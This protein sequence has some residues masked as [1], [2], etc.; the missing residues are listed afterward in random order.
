MHYGSSND[1]NS[2]NVIHLSQSQFL[3]PVMETTPSTSLASSPV[4]TTFSDDSFEQQQY[5]TETIRLNN[6]NID[7]QGRSTSL[8][9]R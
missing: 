9:N 8:S 3:S 5:V 1:E 7:D 4:S 2:N 6:F